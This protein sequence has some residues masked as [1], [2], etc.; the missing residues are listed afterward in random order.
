MDAIT[1]HVKEHPIIF[2]AAMVRAIFEG[3]KT[4]T[5]RIVKPPKWS[6]PWGMNEISLW[7]GAPTIPDDD[8]ATYFIECPY[9]KPGDRLW[10]RETWRPVPIEISTHKKP[11]TFLTDAGRE[12]REDS[13]GP[14]PW[15][16]PIYMPRWA[17]RITLEIVS[18][19]VERL[20]EISETD[21]WAEGLEACDGMFDEKVYA[22][23]KR[24]Q[25]DGYN[26]TFEDAKPSYACLWESINGRGS[27]DANPW[28]WCLEFKRVCA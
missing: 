26:G 10:V 24:M 15:K 27:W 21:C 7:N 13:D 1:P 5:R 14:G 6:M 12:F 9:G 19:R 23:A 2:S 22:M 8:D 3:R 20:Q 16:S 4:Q 17:S 25:S 28:V 11:N 18:V